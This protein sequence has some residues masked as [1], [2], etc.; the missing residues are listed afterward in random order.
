M[1]LAS[2]SSYY[3]AP[4]EIIRMRNDLSALPCWYAEMGGG[5][6]VASEGDVDAFRSQCMG[7]GLVPW[8]T[9]MAESQFADGVMGRCSSLPFKCFPWGWNPALV[10]LLSVKFHNEKLRSSN[11]S[12]V[13]SSVE[14]GDACL[15]SSVGG[16]LDATLFSLPS[17]EQLQRIRTLSGRQQCVKVLADFAA[18]SGICGE[19]VVCSSLDEVLLFIQNHEDVILK[20][21]WSGSGRGLIRTSL[22][23][24]TLNQE[25]WVS[26]ILRTQGSIMAE[27][28]YNK[29]EDFAMEFY[30]DEMHRLSFVGYS[31]FETDSHGNYKGNVLL[32]NERIVE[33]L[34]RYVSAE[35]LMSI[36]Q[37]LL[38]SLT[39]LIGADY[40]GYFG[41]DM[42]ICQE[43]NQSEV[44]EDDSD[45][46]VGNIVGHNS[47]YP[48][49]YVVHPCV[50]INLR[51][52]MGVIA[53]L[54]SDRYLSEHS[55]GIYVVEH[56]GA[57]G[58]ALSFDKQMRNEHPLTVE[59]HKLVQGYFTL[60]P[61]TETT[62]YQC[63][64]IATPAV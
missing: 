29:V 49:T 24:W 40:V 44:L 8:G 56:F 37:Q 62:R 35:L 60:T 12:V 41:V 23:N 18:L 38:V 14:G 45:T 50:E 55:E 64:V 27:P 2:F 63:Y 22:A 5:V 28:I 30:M 20:A 15:S 13:S 61:V 11:M 26:R 6:L 31:L 25:G 3:K 33:R 59:N 43:P 4:R 58:E 42:M 36:Q 9:C 21:P 51:M 34:T 54:L 32:S 16:L 46:S 57:D 52:N 48:I 7:R 39:N 1:A 19:A 10:Q 47:G 53:R 17:M